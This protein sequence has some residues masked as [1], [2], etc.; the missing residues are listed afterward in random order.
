MPLK[1]FKKAPKYFKKMY[2][3]FYICPPKILFYIVTLKKEF[4]GPP[5]PNITV[6]E[7]FH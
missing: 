2:L 7:A 4:M 6:I 1:V 5:L 3:F